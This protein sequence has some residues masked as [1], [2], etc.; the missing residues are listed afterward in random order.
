MDNFCV[1]FSGNCPSLI[2]GPYMKGASA[3]GVSD[4]LEDTDIIPLVLTLKELESVMGISL[5]PKQSANDPSLQGGSGGVSFAPALASLHEDYPLRGSKEHFYNQLINTKRD[6]KQ[7]IRAS[8]TVDSANGGVIYG[9]MATGAGG[10]DHP[11]IS[12]MVSIDSS[13]LQRASST[14]SSGIVAQVKPNMDG[15]TTT[16][17]GSIME[18]VNMDDLNSG[19]D[20]RTTFMIRRLPRY[21]S[22]DQLE[23]LI[24]STGLLDDAYD[25]LYV[26]I[27][28]GKAHANRG[29]AFINF[30]TPQLGALF[31]SIVK[32]SV[33]T[34]L[35]KQL[36]KCD[37]VYAHIQGKDN[38]V[39]NLT[40]IRTPTSADALANPPMETA[41][42][43][44]Y[45]YSTANN[46]L[47]PGLKLF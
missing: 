38:M 8:S 12:R 4:R 1:Y 21:L 34:A 30:R 39:E 18:Y 42:T 40:R 26:P 14:A 44:S 37:I 19:R 47:P 20:M 6:H 9:R 22:S 23:I 13:T 29:Y 27:F 16:E 43:F 7:L 17:A 3:A 35:S 15:I 10:V 46:S 25:L 2:F 28:T 32:F 33:E 41:A 5:L 31:V 24:Q 36:S 45:M 11:S